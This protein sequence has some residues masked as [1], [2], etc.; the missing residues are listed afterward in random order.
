MQADVLNPAEEL[1]ADL[2]ADLEDVRSILIPGGSAALVGELAMLHPGTA[3]HWIPTDVRELPAPGAGIVV[4]DDITHV[5]IA[6]KSIDLVII[7]VT[8]DRDLAR[9]WVALAREVARPLGV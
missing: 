2:A 7:E 9:R 6:A 5:D 8:G 3:I 1:L 4:H